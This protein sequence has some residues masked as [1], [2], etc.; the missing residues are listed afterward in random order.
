MG[1][2][3]YRVYRHE[4]FYHTHYSPDDSYPG[5]LGLQIAAEIP[6]DPD[7]YK[8][9]LAQIRQAL[10][11]HFEMNEE[12]IDSPDAHYRIHTE[13]YDIEDTGVDYIYEIDLDH[14]VFLVD[15]FPMFALNN[16]PETREVFLR[17]FG[18]D[19]YEHRVCA[20]STPD[21]HRYNWKA[22]P[23]KVSDAIVAD[24][25]ARSVSDTCSFLP[26]LLGTT[27]IVSRCEAVR[28]ELYEVF[29]GWAMSMREIAHE[30]RV[31]ETA[32]N[33]VSKD[34]RSTGRALVQLAFGRMIFGDD[35]DDLSRKNKMNKEYDQLKQFIRGDNIKPVAQK[36]SWVVPNVCLC[37]TTHLDDERHR[38]KRILKMVDHI[39]SSDKYQ[40]GSPTY[41]ILFSFFHCV[42]VRVESEDNFK[43]T[44]AMQFLP[45]YFAD[46][47]TTPGITAICSLAYHCLHDT[48]TTSFPD[49]N[50]H[51]PNHFLRRVPQEVL[52]LI[53]DYLA[54]MDLAALCVAAPVFT[55]AAHDILRFPHIEKYRL[56]KGKPAHGRD[57]EEENELGETII[58][59]SRRSLVTKR[60]ETMVNG[61]PGPKLSVGR[62]A[63][64]D[65]KACK[66][67]SVGVVIGGDTYRSVGW[68]VTQPTTKAKE[69]EKKK[70]KKKD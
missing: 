30:I 59:K 31:L 38:K 37:I 3:A 70:K 48:P 22:L 15:S 64:G 16:M 54:P 12:H 69:K 27:G 19:A 29:I 57:W 68:R 20:A 17:S 43:S 65:D 2:R 56:L 4:G 33:M 8:K 67:F 5:V 24:Y 62:G 55:S 44:I 45:D 1:C 23:P 47:Q 41:G 58:L 13:Q 18:F 66:P 14:E 61:S 52:E 39:V 60:F 32:A 10:D 53:T 25:V 26:D 7:E 51:N 9:W 21:K 50:A 42:V 11:H 40:S 28:T 63:G 35:P 49:L 34:L 46:S 36:F 6:R